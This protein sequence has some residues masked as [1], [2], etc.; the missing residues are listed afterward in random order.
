MTVRRT[1]DHMTGSSFFHS[2][3][4]IY[5]NRAT[6]S[7]ELVEHTHDFIEITYV[8]EGSGVH[9]IQNERIPVAQGD[10]FFIPVGVSH[11]FRPT[12]PRPDRK[13]VVYNCIFPAAYIEE[14]MRLFPATASL[15]A[16]FKDPS[17]PWLQ[18]KDSGGFH[19][20]FR[21]LYREYEAQMPGYP[22]VLAAWV[23]LILTALHRHCVEK[24]PDVRKGSAGTWPFIENA[25]GYIQANYAEPV[26]LQELARQAGLSV[27]QFSRLF[28]QQTGLSFSGYLQMCRVEAACRLLQT[29][30]MSIRDTAHSVGYTDLKFFHRLFKRITGVTPLSY[31][32]T[33]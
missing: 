15:F 18:I 20:W 22:A 27:R 33:P 32:K 2:E 23:V 4:P 3:T 7:F 25:I 24:L 5:V 10:V 11:V 14:L 31:R 28:R 17:T 13:L 21:E 12:A 8:S 16:P 29:T 30:R 1:V 19:G 26:T 9:Y 6:E